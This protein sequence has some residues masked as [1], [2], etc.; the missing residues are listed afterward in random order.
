MGYLTGVRIKMNP[1][2]LRRKEKW[3]LKLMLKS[4]LDANPA[5]VHALSPRS[6]WLMASQKSVKAIASIAVHAL[7][8]APLKQSL[9]N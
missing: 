5:L 7:V 6:L 2:T 9:S 4:A 8:H 1:E 3:Q